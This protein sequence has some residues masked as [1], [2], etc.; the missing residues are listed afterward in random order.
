[1]KL[2]GDEEIEISI[3]ENQCEIQPTFWDQPTNQINRIQFTILS[4]TLTMNIYNRL[5][6]PADYRF[7]F[8]P[9]LSDFI[10]ETNVGN[11]QTHLTT[12]GNIIKG[13]KPWF[14]V[15]SPIEENDAFTFEKQ[16]NTGNRIRLTFL[17]GRV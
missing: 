13:M 8:P 3:R 14:I 6:V 15:N 16:N 2:M 4:D 9:S 7:F 5:Y 11:I 10:L 12:E 17:K 1:M